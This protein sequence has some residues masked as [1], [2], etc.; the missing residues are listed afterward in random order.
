MQVVL[1]RVS[2]FNAFPVI[3]CKFLPSL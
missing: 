1:L 3:R 2:D